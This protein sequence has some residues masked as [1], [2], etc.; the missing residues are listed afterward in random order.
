MNETVRRSLVGEHIFAYKPQAICLVGNLHVLHRRNPDSRRACAA[1][2]ARWGKPANL[3][4]GIVRPH[5]KSM[6]HGKPPSVCHLESSAVDSEI[7]REST[8][9]RIGISPPLAVNQSQ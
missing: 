9:R 4:G 2:F 3:A 6:T 5:R 1:S 7:P 8:T